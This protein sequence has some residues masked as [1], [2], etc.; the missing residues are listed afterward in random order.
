MI[1]HP[2]QTAKTR[3]PLVYLISC[4]VLESSS[5]SCIFYS[6][7]QLLEPYRLKRFNQT[8]DLSWFF[9]GIR[10]PIQQGI[11]KLKKALLMQ[12]DRV[13]GDIFPLNKSLQLFKSINFRDD[14]CTFLFL[15]QKDSQPCRHN[16][17]IM[18]LESR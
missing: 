1:N 15:L 11:N 8:S 18:D 2:F 12:E 14:N 7:S 3:S 10:C 4:K 9:K 17:L 16:C 13:I 6:F 5:A